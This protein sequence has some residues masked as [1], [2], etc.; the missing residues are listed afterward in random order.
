MKSESWTS[1]LLHPTVTASLYFLCTGPED[2]ML[3]MYEISA[4]PGHSQRTL[5]PLWPFGL[6]F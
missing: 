5:L 4:L 6:G 2:T 1:K 3:N